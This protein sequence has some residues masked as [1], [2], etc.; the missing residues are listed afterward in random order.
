LSGEA[1]SGRPA[2]R[3]SRWAVDA[4][5][6]VLLVG[7]APYGLVRLC[8]DSRS[9]SRWRA[10]LKDLPARFGPRRPRASR[11][12]C[13][14]VHGV[15]VGEVKAAAR[16][17]E[18]IEGAVPG[19]EVVVTATT[20][21]GYRVARER[22]PGRRIEFYPPD[23][24]WVVE[25]ALD[26]LRPD[27]VVL[28]ESEIWPNFLASLS[29]RGVP[30]VLV[31]GRI[32]ERSAARFRRAGPAART[33]MGSLALV[34]A[35]MPVYADR[36]RALGVPA[37]RLVVT[38]NLKLDNVPIGD[39]PVRSAAYARLFGLDG[40]T[41]LLVA[42]ATHHGE[43]RILGRTV[44]RL[45]AAGLPVRALV[46][47]RHPGRA[48]DAQADLEREGMAV[49]RRSRLAPDGP[50][51][52]PDSVV[53][54]DTVGELESV[55]ALADVAFVGGSLVAHGGHNMM[56]PASLAKPVVVGP[57]TFNFRGEVDLLLAADGIAEVADEEGLFA[58]C[59][60]WRK[61]PAEARAVGVRGRAAILASKGAT[62]R[63]LEVL[64]PWLAR[65]AR[66]AAAGT[67][68]VCALGGGRRAGRRR[69]GGF[70][71]LA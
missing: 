59:V 26:R 63:T 43:E 28:I 21:T 49:V 38:G 5:Y 33:L 7:L 25:D 68:S 22:Y 44:R 20:D 53:L 58:T 36:F 65:L 48:D 39:D 32:S 56:E 57:H 15:S 50:H 11:A 40:T 17:V 12:P 45:R 62:T 41:P 23:L 2:R 9:R 24:S 4:A 14:W 47:P 67:G 35:Q 31:N 64:R 66:P 52:P 70:L 29:R 16:L 71:L 8:L 54:L 51:P 61:D 34:C 18:T 69:S 13:V 10:Y 6:A 37:E 27:L 1:G 3:L 30:V 42:G 19:V 60:R 46:A 55:Y